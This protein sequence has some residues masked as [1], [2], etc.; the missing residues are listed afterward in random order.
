MGTRRAKTKQ[1]RS[2]R[3]LRRPASVIPASSHGA[4]QGPV[5][6]PLKPTRER[7]RGRHQLAVLQPPSNPPCMPSLRQSKNVGIHER[8]PT[9]KSTVPSERC[10]L[11]L[12]YPEFN[13]GVQRWSLGADSVLN[14]VAPT[15][16]HRAGDEKKRRPN[17]GIGSHAP[18]SYVS[19]T[20]HLRCLLPY[21]HRGCKDGPSIILQYSRQAHISDLRQAF[22]AP[23]IRMPSREANVGGSSAVIPPK[24]QQRRRRVASIVSIPPTGSGSGSASKKIALLRGAALDPRSTEH[25]TT[26]GAFTLTGCPRAS[27]RCFTRRGR[28]ARRSEPHDHDESIPVRPPVPSDSPPM[29][30]AASFASIPSISRTASPFS[31]SDNEYGSIPP[32]WGGVL[33]KGRGKGKERGRERARLRGPRHPHPPPIVDPLERDTRV[34]TGMSRAICAACK[35]HGSNFPRCRR[36]GKMWC[37]REC[38]VASVHRCGAG[39]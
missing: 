18:H 15:R 5:Y 38:R 7:Y 33:R 4:P 11:I 8:M 1:R 23:R 9:P 26:V 37:S 34:G 22:V 24:T 39:G 30:P 32:G 27:L 20:G 35:K 13:H 10:H 21:L 14:D 19:S 2:S 25:N 31:D 36:C 28:T 17:P 12:S 29:S 16:Q 3:P 6:C